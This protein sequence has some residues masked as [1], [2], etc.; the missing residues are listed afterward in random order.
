MFLENRTRYPAL[1]FR[2][3]IDDQRFCASVTARITY[4]LT[5]EG[6]REAED[7]VWTVSAEPWQGPHGGPMESDEVFYRGGVDLFVFGSARSLPDDPTR[8]RV[9]V[10]LGNHRPHQIQVF[11]ERLW[12]RQGETLIPGRPRAFETVP[13][14][15]TSAF[16]GSDRWDGLEIPFPDNPL[17]KGFYLEAGAAAG[18]PLPQ[19]ESPD[20]PIRNWDDQPE[21]VAT[22]VAPL[23][24]GPRLKRFLEID[25]TTGAIRRIDPR[26]FN[27]ALPGMIFPEADPGDE[28][29]V[30]GVAG[31]WPPRFAIPDPGLRIRLAF[32]D[33]TIEAAPRID[34]IGI[35]CEAGRVFVAWRYP[36]RY[37]MFPLQR[38]SCELIRLPL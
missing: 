24:F 19:L 22:C 16:G 9:T 6:L 32:D 33:E 34:Q 11:G 21:P 36:F 3:G 28:V 29:E 12:E 15:L 18:R 38:R 25:E 20:A 14:D 13:L 37:R 8:G 17:G 1:L 2:G 4:D 10:R 5:P 26:L 27:T 35:E 31:Q 23:G 7:Q 30:T